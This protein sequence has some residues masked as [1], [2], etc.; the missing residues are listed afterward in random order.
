MTKEELLDVAMNHPANSA[1]FTEEEI[2]K[3]VDKY[4]SD[5]DY[6]ATDKPEYEIEH[7]IALG[8]FDSEFHSNKT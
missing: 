3:R 1:F 6:L 7:M 4:W 8:Y 2:E 5:N